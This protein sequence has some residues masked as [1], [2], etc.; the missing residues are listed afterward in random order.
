MSDKDIIHRIRTHAPA[1]DPTLVEDVI[2]RIWKL[3]DERDESH[4][5]RRMRDDKE[6]IKQ[7]RE[8]RDEARREVCVWQGLDTGNTARDTAKIRGWDCFKNETGTTGQTPNAMADL[9]GWD[10]FDDM[11]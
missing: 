6:L 2:K 3:E 8:E 10:L 1:I 5:W 11:S 4:R 7:L 9:C